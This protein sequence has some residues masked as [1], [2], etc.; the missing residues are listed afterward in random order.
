MSCK[1]IWFT[2]LSGAGK[3]TLSDALSKKLLNLG[4]KLIKI[5]GDVFRKKKKNINNFSKKNILKNNKMIINHVNKLQKKYEFVIVSVISPLL[6]TRK[7]AK[8]KFGKNYFEIFVKCSLKT[9]IKRDTK[10]LYKSAIQ[11]KLKN[12]IGFNSKIAYE[13]SK[14]KK[15]TINTEKYNIK[16]SLDK[17][18]NKII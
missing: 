10:G 13:K 7:E 9:L 5:D 14:Y 16:D 15:I 3:T 17:I 12:L 18:I 2:G 6:E 1:I 11:K 8:K 4:H